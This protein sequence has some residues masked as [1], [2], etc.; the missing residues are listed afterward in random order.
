MLK[1]II[2]LFLLPIISFQ[3]SNSAGN[4]IVNITQINESDP[5]KLSILRS[6]P[7]NGAIGESARNYN[8]IYDGYTE[9]IS[10]NNGSTYL[11]LNQYQFEIVFNNP[12]QKHT[13]STAIRLATK[14]ESYFSLDNMFTTTENNLRVNTNGYGY[15]IG[16]TYYIIIDTT[17]TDIFGNHFAKPETLSFCPEPKIRITN[18]Y[19]SYDSYDDNFSINQDYERKEADTQISL[20]SFPL[21]LSYLSVIF[22]TNLFDSCK[23][24]I[25]SVMN[26]N[27]RIEE[28]H[29]IITPLTSKLLLEPEK[30]YE[31]NLTRNIQNNIGLF[32]PQPYKINIKTDRFRGKTKYGWHSYST[33]VYRAYITFNDTVSLENIKQNFEMISNA[34]TLDSI[35]CQKQEPQTIIINVNGPYS[36]KPFPLFRILPFK[37]PRGYLLKDTII[38]KYYPDY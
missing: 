9:Y 10:M 36:P 5:T 3:C 13:I 1:W 29:L 7:K 20:D 33:N 18:I 37:N 15:E 27:A 26:F 32:L 24:T 30:V 17:L 2:T 23:N 11:T 16:E 4:N 25:E 12:I 38:H 31:I 19:S 35:D 34:Y 21:S 14:D 6:D 8:G 28:D 22:N